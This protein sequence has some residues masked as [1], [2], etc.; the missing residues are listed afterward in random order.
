MRLRAAGRTAGQVSLTASSPW[1]GKIWQ[2]AFRSA[3]ARTPVAPSRTTIWWRERA[4]REILRRDAGLRAPHRDAALTSAACRHR[5]RG[6]PPLRGR[7]RRI[8]TRLRGRIRSLIFGPAHRSPWSSRMAIVVGIPRR[9]SCPEVEREPDKFLRPRTYYNVAKKARRPPFPF[10]A[11][12]VTAPRPRSPACRSPAPPRISTVCGTPLRLSMRYEVVAAR[13]VGGVDQIEAGLIDR[14]G[15]SSEA[16]DADVRHARVPRPRRSSRSP[17]TYFH[18]VD[19]KRSCP[20]NIPP[21]DEAAS[22]IASGSCRGRRSRSFRRRR[23][24]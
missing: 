19:E 24:G 14:D 10:M 23:R 4:T 16:R 3:S 6:R 5:R 17:R 18:N 7:A 9:R 1:R 12:Y 22:A 2:T 11:F 20:R 15:G 21:R 8:R 13:I